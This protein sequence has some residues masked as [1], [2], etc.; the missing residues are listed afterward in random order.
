MVEN[1]TFVKINSISY[2]DY[3]GYVYDLEIEP[4][5]NY[6]ANGILCH[7]TCAAVTIAEGL[8]EMVAKYNKRIFVLANK[9]LR[10]NFEDTLYDV[11]KEANEKYPGSLQCTGTTYYLPPKRREGPVAK[12]QRK[13]NIREKLVQY[14]ELDMGY[15]KFA[16]FVRKEVVGEGYDIGEYFSN[17]VFVIDEAHNLIVSSS[18][19]TED[20][21]GR[22]IQEKAEKTREVLHQIFKK[23]TNTKL[24]LLT[25]TPMINEIDDI[26]ILINLLR[27][28]DKRPCAGPSALTKD[29]S[30][31]ITM[32]NLDPNKFKK[33]VRGYVSFFRGAH[34]ATFPLTID[35]DTYDRKIRFDQYGDS[36]RD[37][38][39]NFKDLKVVTC[40]MSPFHFYN[41]FRLLM[42]YNKNN[43]RKKN[44][45]QFF[46]AKDTRDT[47]KIQSTTLMM[48]MSNSDPTVGSYKLT[49]TFTIDKGGKG[50][51]DKYNYGIKTEIL[52]VEQEDDL[53]IK[54]M[55]SSDSDIGY[56]LANVSVKF[57]HTLYDLINT[58]GTNFVYT[59][60]V[61]S[62]TIPLCLMLEQ[63]GYVRWHDNLTLMADGKYSGVDNYLNTRYQKF[64]CICGHLYKEHNPK[65]IGNQDY[66]DLKKHRFLQGTYIRVDGETAK[67]FT[68][69][70]RKIFNSRENRN[71]EIIKVLVGGKS[72]SEG[73]DL[74]YVRSVHIINPW[75]NLIQIEQTIGRAVRL[76]SHADLDEVAH[77]EVKVFKY[78]AIPP[79]TKIAPKWS[80]VDLIKEHQDTRDLILDNVNFNSKQTWL[81]SIS[82]DLPRDWLSVDESVYSRALKKDYN[83]KFT[84]RLLKI[85]AVDCYLNY[86]ANTTFPFDTD[87]SR[88]CDY[89]VCKYKCESF[90]P[91]N[92]PKKLQNLDTYS[93]YFIEP[94]VKETQLIISELFSRNWALSLPSIIELA[95]DIDPDLDKDVIYLTLEYML[96]DP[97]RIDPVPVID[98]YKRYGHIIYRHPFYVFQPNEIIDDRLPYYNR[99]IPYRR[100]KS[101]ADLKSILYRPKVDLTSMGGL[102][103]KILDSPLSSRVG[104]ASTKSPVETSAKRMI[105]NIENELDPAN[106]RDEIAISMEVL[107]YYSIK[108]H[109]YVIK[110]RVE[111]FISGKANATTKK[112][113]IYY[114]ENFLLANTEQKYNRKDRITSIPTNGTW[115]YNMGN[116][117]MSLDSK[118]KDTKWTKIK[119]ESKIMDEI[120]KKRPG[121]VS[122]QREPA[123]ELYGFINDDNQD[124]EKRF[125]ILD[126]AKRGTAAKRKYSKDFNLKT[127]TT[128]KVCTHYGNQEL[129]NFAKKLGLKIQKNTNIRPLC[130]MIERELR[131]LNSTDGQHYW[132]LNFYNFRRKNPKKSTGDFH[133]WLFK[134]Y[135][136]KLDE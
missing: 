134:F 13:K 122:L 5:H 14:Y 23:A 75:H 107:D 59:R 19:D 32:E 29:S 47:I 94:K 121:G 83:I 42:I 73:V 90:F 22:I 102:Q 124:N 79:Q 12:K 2:I 125:K 66:T 81:K 118:S 54:D 68:E 45:K 4:Y 123:P 30:S 51:V 100:G 127:L 70:S 130:S 116:G 108:Q 103:F 88:E 3:D 64:R 62:G 97:P 120:Y 17:T 96:G 1:G 93:F 133:D 92:L 49:P 78:V 56:P 128:G 28:N 117:F 43:K 57:Y 34:P 11:S 82:S 85:S 55:P 36:L 37:K 7:N 46:Y 119:E 86:D 101:Q 53:H 114:L 129:E 113:L 21:E 91:K 58:F 87:G 131:K 27:A 115:V 110:S 18:K 77:M 104:K 24:I 41:H 76:C 109:E 8:K 16:N 89:D 67:E 15:T 61:E 69:T 98:Q 48:P 60:Y 33:F 84:E 105:N 40:E 20:E 38:L 25:A 44:G 31:K 6:I 52:S 135:R 9:L 99:V 65:Y 136:L 35:M 39:P 10:K 106:K 112:I 95:H 71:S 111:R 50:Q 132:F 72:M 126:F 80:L 63:N 26:R 74:K